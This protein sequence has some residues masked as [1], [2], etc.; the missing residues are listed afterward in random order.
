MDETWIVQGAEPVEVI[1]W[2]EQLAVL[3]RR[4]QA[5]NALRSQA[6]IAGASVVEP[7]GLPL[8]ARSRASHA[9][10]IYARWPSEHEPFGQVHVLA[11]MEEEM[12]RVLRVEIASDPRFPLLGEEIVW[13]FRSRFPHSVRGA[14]GRRTRLLM[15]INRLSRSRHT[16]APVL[17]C[18]VWLEEQLALTTDPRERSR[19]FRPWLQRYRQ[20][21]GVDPADPTR[22]FRAAVA[23]CERRLRAREKA[24]Q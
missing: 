17:A 22:S 1:E 24:A 2:L 5:Q 18:N 6:V 9:A 21:R 13:H 4:E 15:W 3:A 20:L 11:L 19:L 7:Q 8:P 14:G 12:D 23:G 10:A 16:G